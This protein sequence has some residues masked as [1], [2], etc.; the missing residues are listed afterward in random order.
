VININEVGTNNIIK[1][2]MEHLC[3]QQQKEEVN[4]MKDE[5]HK[6]KR[7]GSPW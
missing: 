3:E 6:K 7:N 2:T 1:T 5:G 4:I